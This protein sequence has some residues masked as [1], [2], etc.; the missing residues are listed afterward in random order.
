MTAHVTTA[1]TAVERS[2]RSNGARQPWLLETRTTQTSAITANMGGRRTAENFATNAH[3]KRQALNAAPAAPGFSRWRHH[4]PTVARKKNVIT[5]SEVASAPWAKKV[6]E[7][8]K[9]PSERN[10]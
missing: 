4:A 1:W 2:S 10:A 9:S 8:T 5:T 7:K 3:P 6:G